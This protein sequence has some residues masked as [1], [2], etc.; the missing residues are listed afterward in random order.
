MQCTSCR[1]HSDNL[2]EYSRAVDLG[3]N[4]K[5]IETIFLC[6]PCRVINAINPKYVSARVHN[7]SVKTAPANV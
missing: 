7:E 3:G 1:A 2:R 5:T 4:R 6:A